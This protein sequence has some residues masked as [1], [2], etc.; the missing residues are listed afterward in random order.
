VTE[1]PK[2]T[3]ILVPHGTEESRTY[4]ISYRT[5]RI[6]RA[7]GVALTLVLLF[8]VG[9]WGVMANR[10]TRVGDLEAQVAELQAAQSRVPFLVEQLGELESQYAHL[11]SLFA[12][13]AE[14]SPGDL[15]LPPPGGRR[16]RIREPAVEEALPNSWPLAE[17]G[18][19]TRGRFEGE[20]GG[21]P[22]LD[23]AIPTDSYVRAAGAGTVLE[24]GEDETYGIFVRIDHGNGYQTFYAHNAQALV[25]VGEVVRKNEAIALSGSTGQSTAPHLHFEILRNGELV[26]PLELVTQP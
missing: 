22:G 15:W 7:A 20:A 4:R 23:I 25:D 1:P 14:A 16:D 10:S 24:T 26:D 11:R 21:H 18:F 6:L 12:P 5:L 2:L 3:V 13:G 8:L 9:S 19:I 17:R